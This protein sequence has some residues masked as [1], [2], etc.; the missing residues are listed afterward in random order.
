MLIIGVDLSFGIRGYFDTWWLLLLLS[1]LDSHRWRWGTEEF[2]FGFD[3][4][5]PQL[6]LD[7]RLPLGNNNPRILSNL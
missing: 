3:F 2:R 6:D 1:E 7:I 5:C 4:Q